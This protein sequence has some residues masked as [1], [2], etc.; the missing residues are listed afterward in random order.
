MFW[1]VFH[2][3]G[4]TPGLFGT[5]KTWVWLPT[6]PVDLFWPKSNT[7]LQG[8]VFSPL[9]H[10]EQLHCHIYV[11][12]GAHKIIKRGLHC[13]KQHTFTLSPSSSHMTSPTPRCEQTINLENTREV[14]KSCHVPK[15]AGIMLLVLDSLSSKFIFVTRN[16]LERLMLKLKLPILWPPDVKNWL[17]WK[18]PDAGKDWRQ[19]QKGTTEDEMVEWHHRLNGHEFE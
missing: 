1:N 9:W 4:K 3:K 13:I 14:G 5:L 19:K 8:G 7:L 6:Q 10:I 18:D 12:S 17:I 16:C 2:C 11:F 15:T